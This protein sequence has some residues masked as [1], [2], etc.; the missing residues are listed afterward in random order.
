M[1]LENPRAHKFHFV[2]SVNSY[3][4]AYRAVAV[5]LFHWVLDTS[6]CESGN[7]LLNWL[8]F[9]LGG[10]KG[11]KWMQVQDSHT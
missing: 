8:T 3:H 1:L 2:S 4:R 9:Q 10:V 7:V 5:T 11:C 6:G